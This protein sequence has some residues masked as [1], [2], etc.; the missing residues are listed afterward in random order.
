MLFDTYS[1]V[2]NDVLVTCL[3]IAYVL[4]LIH[5]CEALVSKHFVSAAVSRK[6]VHMGA[7]SW[8]VFWPLYSSIPSDDNDNGHWSWRLNALIPAAK[9]ME[10]FVK[11]A[12]LQDPN[13]KDVKSM[14]RSGN[15]AELLLGPLQFT[16]VMT[17]VGL[18]L[19][20]ARNAACLIMGAVGIGDGMA[21]LMASRYG[22]HKYTSPFTTAST[23]LSS[24]SMKKNKNDNADKKKK[25]T[26]TKSIEGSVAVFVGT[27]VG[28]YLY[29]YI[30]IVLPSNS[31]SS[32]LLSTP[33]V[34]LSGL[35]AALV[36]GLAPSNIDNL[37]VPVAMYF[38]YAVF[39]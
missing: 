38:M 13:D 1:N 17:V 29:A 24:G 31:F 2:Q 9:G 16:V 14:S 10:L 23:F 3:V 32:E 25:T 21:P 18:F 33:L 26:P 34:L 35:V 12:L 7:A 19:F 28:Y 15:P 5:S 11:G 4:L 6:I 27:V 36:E 22:K 8:L 39:A 20:D 37:A 30:L